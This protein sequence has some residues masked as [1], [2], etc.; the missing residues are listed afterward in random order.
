M[1][2]NSYKLLN[3]ILVESSFKRASNIDF[4]NTDLKNNIDIDIN[5][6]VNK[7]I[8]IVTVT[9]KFNTTINSEPIISSEIKTA[10]SFEFSDDNNIPLESFGYINAPAIIFPFIREHLSNLSMKAGIQPILLPPVNFVKLAR[11]EK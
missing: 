1:E 11:K 6:N 7:N 10:G 2:K 4:S 3:I 5:N 9:L 8:L